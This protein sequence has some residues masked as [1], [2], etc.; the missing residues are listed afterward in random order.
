ME[1]Q[2]ILK[3]DISE[4]MSLPMYLVFSLNLVLKEAVS[5]YYQTPAK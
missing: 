4:I 1:K 3:N 5:K 2:L